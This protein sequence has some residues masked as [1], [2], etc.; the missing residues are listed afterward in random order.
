MS[1]QALRKTTPTVLSE[2]LAEQAAEALRLQKYKDAIEFFKQLVKQDS[3]PQWR[4]GLAEA[5]VGRARALATRG[6][7][8]EAEIVLGNATHADGSSREPV[9]LLRCLV[10]QGQFQKA[11]AYLINHMPESGEDARLA[12]L[13]AALFLAVPTELRGLHDA[14]SPCGRWLRAAAAATAALNSWTGAKPAEEVDSLLSKIPLNSPFKA[15]RL[16]LKSLLLAPRD[17]LKARRM[18]EGVAQDSPFAPLGAAAQ[19]AIASASEAPLGGWNPSDAAQRSFVIETSGLS[20][21]ASQ[22]AMRLAEAEAAG[23]GALFFFLV[24]SAEQ[25]DTVDLRSACRN[26]LPRAPDRVPQFE[27]RFGALEEW[28]R[29]RILA[30]SAEEAGRWSQAERC[31]GAAAEQLLSDGSTRARLSAGVVYRHLAELALKHDSIEGEDFRQDPRLWYLRRSVEADPDYL[32]AR[33]QLIDLLRESEDPDEQK[34]WHAQADAAAARFPQEREA[35]LCAIDS[36]AQRKAFKKAAGYA[37]KLLALDPINLSARQRMIDL[38]IAQARKQCRAERPDLA[39]KALDEAMRWERS[40]KPSA[41]LRLNRGLLGLYRD[42]GAEAEARL[43]EGVELAG[44]ATIGWFRAA[45][46]E[47]LLAPP[48]YAPVQLLRDELDRLLPR[49]PKTLEIV[50]VAAALGASEVKEAAKATAHVVGTFCSWMSKAMQVRFS[51][52]EFHAVAEVLLRARLYELLGKLANAARWREPRALVWRFYEIVA[53]TENNPD[54]LYCAESEEIFDMLDEAS[55]RQAFAWRSRM[56]RYLN[57]SGDDPAARRRARRLASWEQAFAE[58]DM[59]SLLEDVFDAIHPEEF[60]RLL[61]K[62]GHADAPRA[63][64]AH[65]AKTPAL[66]K[67][68]PTALERIVTMLITM[69]KAGEFSPF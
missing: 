50:A 38:L 16:I 10:H 22:T 46:E 53:R 40:D 5:Y 12:E 3:R 29:Q 24:K 13:A 48:G 39:E 61:R 67:V 25:F 52:D 1:K 19:A 65:L 9:L 44:G 17:G 21:A 15:A 66:R 23:P 49:T 26:L 33:L 36:A 56:Q 59:T 18:L 68:T 14:E 7:F 43:R 57:S 35:L 55:E 47:A 11:L 45:I 31:W 20:T 51:P 32:P 58:D 37:Q 28:E 64:A 34:D 69:V 62:H 4:E 54:R 42:Q 63:I 27:K 60:K 41:S 30:L 6:M 2:R 8:K